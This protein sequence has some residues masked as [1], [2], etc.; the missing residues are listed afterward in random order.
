M[1]MVSRGP[2]RPSCGPLWTTQ[3]GNNITRE[4]YYYVYLSGTTTHFPSTSFVVDSIEVSVRRFC[5]KSTREA[6]SFLLGAPACTKILIE[7]N[8]FSAVTQPSKVRWVDSESA[9]GFSDLWHA[10]CR[11]RSTR[12]SRVRG[13]SSTTA[14]VPSPW[15]ASAAPS[16]SP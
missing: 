9:G 6:P 16:S 4:V 12:E 7:K 11:W 8:N 3:R 5:C 15:A 10:Y 14:A 1:P 13:E 2:H